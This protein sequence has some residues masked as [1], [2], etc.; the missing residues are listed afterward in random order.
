MKK[1]YEPNI[2]LNTTIQN[3]NN[4]PKEKKSQNNDYDAKT[5]LNK[6]AYSD[7]TKRL[8]YLIEKKIGRD[9]LKK[10]HHI[11]LFTRM[12]Y[13]LKVIDTH[14]DS[15]IS[16]F[17]RQLT[18]DDFATFITYLIG[19]A[20]DEDN[21]RDKFNKKIERDY[22][23]NIN[24]AKFQYCFR[25][26]TGSDFKDYYECNSLSEYIDLLYSH[27]TDIHYPRRLLEKAIYDYY[28]MGTTTCAYHEKTQVFFSNYYFNNFYDLRKNN[29]LI[30][31]FL[32]IWETYNS[33]SDEIFDFYVDPLLNIL[34]NTM[35]EFINQLDIYF[36]SNLSFFKNFKY[37]KCFIDMSSIPIT[38]STESIIKNSQTK[39]NTKNLFPCIAIFEHYLIQKHLSNIE[40]KTFFLCD[41]NA[42]TSVKNFRELQL[43]PITDYITNISYDEFVFF[44]T[45]NS[46][47]RINTFHKY[48]KLLLELDNKIK[49]NSSYFGSYTPAQI[50]VRLDLDKA[51]DLKILYNEFINLGKDS[52]KYFGKDYGLI[53]KHLENILSQYESLKIH[54]NTDHYKNDNSNLD[55]IIKDKSQVEYTYSYQ[56][57]VFLSEKLRRGYYYEADMAP[58]FKEIL[59]LKH[60][61]LDLFTSISRIYSV[62]DQYKLFNE[63]MSNF[64]NML[65]T[66][67]NTFKLSH[68]KK[69]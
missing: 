18:L 57:T 17:K 67:E 48:I 51:L 56:L 9:K 37:L 59:Q 10:Q 62:K 31:L 60:Q 53:V 6:Q 68:R 35:Q 34:H 47:I 39:T 12:D 66:Y 13:L 15:P 27:I 26:Y 32:D 11:S 25:Y 42:S 44:C 20:G 3:P 22:I 40:K 46:K 54:E 63:F 50:K 16:I 29:S 5:G 58:H 69:L 61:L 49:L 36:D 28:A 19:N 2:N 55:K 7:E 21:E 14:P 23:K 43:M 30:I 8:K 45:N 4:V 1:S 38:F 64:F 33:E 65:E 41:K 24:T 52:Y